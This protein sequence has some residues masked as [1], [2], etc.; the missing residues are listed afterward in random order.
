MISSIFYPNIIGKTV[1]RYWDFTLSRS[2]G[3]NIV[4]EFLNYESFILKLTF[5]LSTSIVKTF[6]FTFCHTETISEGLDT[7]VSD[8]CEI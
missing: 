8:N 3:K 5:S 4:E 7:K 1:N 2:V 6:T